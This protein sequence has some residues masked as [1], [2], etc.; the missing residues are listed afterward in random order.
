MSV[1]LLL[2]LA[3]IAA[4]A[5]LAALFVV[6]RQ[7]RTL[8]ALRLLAEQSL[9]G[10]RAEAET[11]RAALRATD[12]GI[13]ERIIA[14]RGAYDM[15]MEQMR[16]VLSREQGELRLALAEAQRKSTEQIGAQFEP[17]VP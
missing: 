17:R 14:L 5:A 8:A 15:A 13:A 10:A 1:L 3:S 9:A 7:A 6:A 12:T 2:A 4:A 16:T 11:T